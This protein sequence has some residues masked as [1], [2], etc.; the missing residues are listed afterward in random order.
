MS[1][2]NRK[3]R[4]NRKGMFA[5]PD[6]PKAHPCGKRHVVPDPESTGPTPETL[7]RLAEQGPTDMIQRFVRRELISNDEAQALET[8]AMIRR[9]IGVAEPRYKSLTDPMIAAGFN[10]ANEDVMSWA[11]GQYIAAI[12]VLTPTQADACADVADNR[13]PLRARD[14]TEAAAELVKI[15]IRGERKAA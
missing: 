15:Y 13:T 8:F 5:A 1:K 2:S 11:R 6:A 3:R 9:C 14:V 4:R 10:H 7:L 12:E